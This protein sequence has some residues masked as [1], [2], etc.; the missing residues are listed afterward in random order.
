MPDRT[1]WPRL[2][3]LALALPL[4]AVRAS[5]VRAGGASPLLSAEVAPA[6]LPAD[7]ATTSALYLELLGPNGQPL[8]LAAATIVALRSSDPA[9][10]RTP[11]TVRIA[12]GQALVAVPVTTTDT[13]GSVTLAASAPGMA[14]TGASLTTVAAGSAQGGTITLTVNPGTFLRGSPGP[15]WA[16]VEL[17]NAQ[18]TPEVAQAPV[19]LHLVSSAPPVLSGPATVTIAAGQYTATA[20]LRVGAAGRVTLTA[21]GNGFNPGIA[22]TAVDPPGTGAV[23]LHAA[24]DPPVALPGTTPQMV[25]QA[26]DATGTPVAFPCGRV[27]LSSNAPDT[28]AVPASAVPTCG[29]DADAVAVSASAAGVAGKVAVTLAAQ[30]LMPTTLQGTVVSARAARLSAVVTPLTLD[31]GGAPQGW[32]TIQARDASGAPEVVT[33]AVDL[34]LAGAGPGVPHTVTLP[35]GA[36]SV[37]VPLN[38]LEP[39]SAPEV[40]ISGPGF[41]PTTVRLGAGFPPRAAAGLPAARSIRIFGRRL[42]LK[43]LMLAQ[44]IVVLALGIGLWISG[45][46]RQGGRPA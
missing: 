4:V 1:I 28:L 24:L 25:V 9:V 12:A 20:D 29:R 46:R 26:T 23:E 19:T 35:A 18:G 31:Y 2:W 17:L 34:R 16:T 15:A 10:A 5:P 14:A 39:A 22:H 11:A 33:Q 3:V 42:A 21:L 32:L 13:P 40:T 43:W 38:G 45:S 30:G 36:A 8:P 6:T 41:T 27:F 37:A 44:A 7:G